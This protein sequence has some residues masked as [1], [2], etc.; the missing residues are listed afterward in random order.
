MPTP[1]PG[2]MDDVKARFAAIATQLRHPM[3]PEKK[4]RKTR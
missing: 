1:K 2:E 4:E 3:P